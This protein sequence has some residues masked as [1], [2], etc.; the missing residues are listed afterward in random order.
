MFLAKDVAEWIEERDGYTVSRKVDDDEK[1]LHTICVA[2]QNRRAKF[3]TE[4]GFYE[5]LMQ[6]R[7]PIAKQIFGGIK[8]EQFSSKKHKRQIICK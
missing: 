5:V 6:S 8:N 4:D 2:G 7:K 1:V 3:L